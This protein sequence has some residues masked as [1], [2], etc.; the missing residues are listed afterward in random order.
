MEE[1]WFVDSP[2]WTETTI[3]QFLDV[4]EGNENWN[5][6]DKKTFTLNHLKGAADLFAKE[7][8]QIDMDWDTIKLKLFEQFK[9]QVNI[10]DKVEMKRNLA[11]GENE[12][13]RVFYNRCV[14]YQYILSDDYGELVMDNDIMINFL[15]GMNRQI[16]NILSERLSLSENIVDLNLC[17]S[18]AEMIEAEIASGEQIIAPVEDNNGSTYEDGAHYQQQSVSSQEGYFDYS[19]NNPGHQAVSNAPGPSMNTYQTPTKKIIQKSIVKSENPTFKN[20]MTPA[21]VDTFS[22]PK[23]KK[24]NPTIKRE[25]QNFGMM[26]AASMNAAGPSFDSEYESPNKKARNT[27]FKEEGFTKTPDGKII[28]M[29]PNCGKEFTRLDNAKVHA[30]KKHSPDQAIECPLCKYYC[31]KNTYDWNEHARKVHQMS[32]NDMKNLQILY[33]SINPTD[34]I[35]AKRPDGK[36]ACLKCLDE[37]GCHKTFTRMDNAK[38]HFN[39]IHGHTHGRT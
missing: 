22:L 34:P 3:S 35:L 18:E 5:D 16:F 11:Q 36:V 9:C 31:A 19:Q 33:S 8:L 37:Q 39:K 12:T 14:S 7:H 27:P 29:A 4:I 1:L 20:K 21:I 38:V 6:V 13:L 10:W 25:N 23:V 30:I 24:E 28:C 17:V 2:V 26:A 32:A 15:H